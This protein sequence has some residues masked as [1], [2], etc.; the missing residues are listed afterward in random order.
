MSRKFM[1]AIGV[2]LVALAGYWL[3]DRN[4]AEAP[5]PDLAPVGATLLEGLGDYS[6]PVTSGGPAWR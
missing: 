4:K 5:P 3:Y 2:A 1:W 6:M